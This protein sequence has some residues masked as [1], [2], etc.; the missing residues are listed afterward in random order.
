MKTNRDVIKNRVSEDTILMTRAGNAG[1]ANIPP[2]LVG[3]VASGFLINIHVD[4]TK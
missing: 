2:D 4:L 1:C 3:G